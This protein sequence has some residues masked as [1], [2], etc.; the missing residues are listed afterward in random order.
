VLEGNRP[1]STRYGGLAADDY[2]HSDGR[3]PLVLL[4]GY[5]FDRTM[6]RSSLAELETLDPGRRA[7][8][9]DL[10]GHGESPDARSYSFQAVVG[11]IR[12]AVLDAGVEAP[13]LVGHSGGAGIAVMYG[14]AFPSRGVVTVD[15]SLMVG[16]LAHMLQAMRPALEGQD[17]DRAWAAISGQVFGLDELTPDVRSV[18]AD[19]SRPRPAVL[20]G[21]WQDL[22]DRAPREIQT[23]I[24]DTVTAIRLAGL[25]FVAVAGREPSPA[26]S[27]WLATEFPE[28]RTLVWAR[29]G[30]FPHLTHPREFAQLLAETATWSPRQRIGA[31]VSRPTSPHDLARP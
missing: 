12:A 27:T 18:V 26:E 28:A 8:A 14:A 10:P 3:P 19:T 9:I 16:E 15:G 17:F 23:M 24:Y 4:N 21:Y 1:R 30:H 11:A 6:W 13:V 29:S 31:R 20:L 25:P 5:T 7:V 22:L 2:G